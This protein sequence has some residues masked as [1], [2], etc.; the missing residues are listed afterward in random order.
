MND[1]AGITPIVFDN[2]PEELRSL[3]QWVLWKAE[4][5]TKVPYQA[6]GYEAK[7]N[8]PTTWTTYEAARAAFEAGGFSGIGLMFADGGG[9][10][11]IDLDD[12][13]RDGQV[14]TWAEQILIDCA[15]YAEVSPSGD[16]IK[17]WGRGSLPRNFKPDKK[18]IPDELIPTDDPGHIELYDHRRFFTVTGWQVDG[19]P[20]SLST[21]NG[22]LDRIVGL[23]GNEKSEPST[24]AS[25]QAP[26]GLVSRSAGRKYLERWA[27]HKIDYALERVSQALDGEKH[28]TRYAMARLLGGL[29]PHGLATEDSIERALFEANPP[30][31][32]AQR[33]ERK[34]I[35]DGIREGRSAPLQLPPEP[36]QPRFNSG[37]FACCP[38]H[39]RVLDA[40]KNG[41]GYKCR[42]RDAS[43]DSGWCDFWWDGDGYVVPRAVDPDTGEVI[44]ADGSL[45]LAANRSDEGNA[46][47][48]EQLSGADLRYCHTRQKWL[49][50]DGSRWSIDEIGASRRA[51]V[52]TVRARFHAA[53]GIPDAT[54]RQKFTAWCIGAENSGKVDS[55]LKAAIS[56][57]SFATTI[58]LWDAD[59]MLAAAKGATIDLRAVVHRAVDRSDYLT[60]RLGAQYE[61]EATCPRWLQ[62]LGEIFAANAELIAFIQRA[63]GY[64]LTGDVREQKIFLL[65]GGGANGKST[66][67]KVLMDLLGTYADNASF[68]TFDANRR[69]EASN[70]LAKLRGKRF[71]TVIETEE[72]KRLAESKVK[73]V[74]GSDMITCRFLYAE[75]FSYYPTYKIWLAMNHLPAIR[76]TDNGIWRRILLIPFNQSFVGREDKQL[77]EALDAELD[78]ILQ[79]AL[80]GLRAWHSRGLDPPEIVT[81]AVTSYRNDSDQIGRWMD[82]RCLQM[83]NLFLPSG[84]GYEDYKTWCTANGEEPVSQNKWSR[85]LNDKG[86][87]PNANKSNR[88]WLHVGLKAAHDDESS[89]GT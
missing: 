58:D 81:S 82:E 11:G 50:W 34:T 73:S 69:N 23:L 22:A 48:L 38:T 77:A 88:G 9:L 54:Q 13:I 64:C 21:V 7:S 31:T 30:K 39:E 4:R 67:L 51:M 56:R 70:D 42:S 68:E 49:A 44:E 17:L 40:A 76:G 43:T 83:P 36:E 2:I 86:L 46:E 14:A 41:N 71:V 25:I 10:F 12:C 65:H 8:D 16:G 66:F 35:R 84:K 53:V 85:R 37:G 78:G 74:T 57:P 55:A 24:S 63:V 3:P 75:Y 26:S 28:N 18:K 47:C 15:T 89:L 20:A 52:T 1:Q 33:S 87:E 19:V 72:G 59:P 79:W 27:Q 62:F 5:N 60:M 45:L 61:P 6:S 80:E 29:L 32:A